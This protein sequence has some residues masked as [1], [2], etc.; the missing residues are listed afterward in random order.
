MH[1]PP[2]VEEPPWRWPATLRS[3][4][5]HLLASELVLKRLH[6]TLAAAANSGPKDFEE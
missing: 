3:E 6:G 1:V 2:A 4:P 5:Y